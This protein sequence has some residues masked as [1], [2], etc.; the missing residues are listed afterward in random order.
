[1][2]EKTQK[3]KQAILQKAEAQKKNIVNRAKNQSKN[4][5]KNAVN[6]RNKVLNKAKNQSHKIVNNAKV[7]RKNMLANTRNKIKKLRQNQ[8][9]RLAKRKARLSKR[10]NMMLKRKK[11]NFMMNLNMKRKNF[12]NWR[13]KATKKLRR[14]QGRKEPNPNKETLPASEKIVPSKAEQERNFQECSSSIVEYVNKVESLVHNEMDI[15]MTYT[16]AEQCNVLPKTTTLGNEECFANLV[17][18]YTVLSNE[19]KLYLDPVAMNDYDTIVNNIQTYG[20]FIVDIAQGCSQAANIAKETTPEEPVATEECL[21]S[22]QRALSKF[23]E[24]PLADMPYQM[25]EQITASLKYSLS[26]DSLSQIE[27]H[28]KL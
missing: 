21:S 1:M 22:H 24:E 11:K 8:N 2:L 4:M 7:H 18:M 27:E 9:Q 19:V 5:L 23:S 25:W 14:N 6:G 28:C 10:Q 26:M 16:T 3:Q 20:D 13:V 15:D 17:N 12:N